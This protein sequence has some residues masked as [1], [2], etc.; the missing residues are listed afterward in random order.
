MIPV[1]L[2]RVRMFLFSF[3]LVGVSSIIFLLSFSVFSFS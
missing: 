3:F 1:P 2:T